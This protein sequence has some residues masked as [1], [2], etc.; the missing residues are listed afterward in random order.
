[1]SPIL[2]NAYRKQK[3]IVYHD[4]YKSDLYS[5]GLILLEVYLHKLGIEQQT[6]RNIIKQPKLALKVALKTNINK[7]I[8][9]T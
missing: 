7:Y 3:I 2:K 6:I 4:E 8:I 5:L 1:M 9:K